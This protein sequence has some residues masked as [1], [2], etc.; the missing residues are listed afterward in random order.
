M[1]DDQKSIPQ[2]DAIYFMMG[3]LNRSEAPY[4]EFHMDEVEF[5][6]YKEIRA[7]YD[8][9]LYKEVITISPTTDEQFKLRT[10]IKLQ[11]IFK[12]GEWAVIRAGEIIIHGKE[13]PSI[14]WVENH[15]KLK[16]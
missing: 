10:L 15:H 8:K 14:N 5:E 9:A 13:Y 2:L 11:D 6:R 12:E 3:I 16:D 1:K 7:Y 4:D